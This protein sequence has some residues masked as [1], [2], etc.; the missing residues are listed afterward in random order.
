MEENVVDYKMGYFNERIR[1]LQNELQ[2]LQLR[3]TMAQSELA[4]TQKAQLEYTNSI[5]K[6]EVTAE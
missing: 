1:A 4:D 5:K 2:L 6:V 3:F